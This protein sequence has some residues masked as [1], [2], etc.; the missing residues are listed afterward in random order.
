[1]SPH[2]GAAEQRRVGIRSERVTAEGGGTRV[3]CRESLGCWSE[4]ARGG[5]ASSNLPPLEG[6]QASRRSKCGGNVCEFGAIPEN[7]LRTKT[8]KVRTNLPLCSPSGCQVLV[9]PESRRAVRRELPGIPLPVPRSTPER[10]VT[11][12]FVRPPD[13][14]DGLFSVS[15]VNVRPVG[16]AAP[17]WS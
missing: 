14:A 11:L 16:P 2:R 10:L 7:V 3:R 5:S 6:A 12:A 8:L 15:S 4:G 13:A 1:M 17:M 9:R